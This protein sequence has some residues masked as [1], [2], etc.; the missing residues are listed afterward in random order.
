MNASPLSPPSSRA[1]GGMIWQAVLPF[2]W[3]CWGKGPGDRGTLTIAQQLV[4]GPYTRGLC[5]KVVS[6]S[7]STERDGV[8]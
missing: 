3:L 6:G 5:A 4:R 7:F 1:R 8:P 2:P